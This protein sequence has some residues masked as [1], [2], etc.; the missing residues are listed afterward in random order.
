[1]LN[2]TNKFFEI[3]KNNVSND[4][5]ITVNPGDIRLIFPDVSLEPISNIHIPIWII[6]CAIVIGILL[7]LFA[8]T[9]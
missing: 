1:M 5:I 9:K 4:Q 3:T 6:V 7:L 2:K 8:R